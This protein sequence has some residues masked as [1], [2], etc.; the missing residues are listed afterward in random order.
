MT[1]LG[2]T[3]L[4]W[5][6]DHMDPEVKAKLPCKHLKDTMS[7]EQTL[8]R[9]LHYP[10]YKKGEEEPGAVRAAAHE[11][12]NLIT[13]L[14]AGSSKGLQVKCPSTQKWHEVPCLR[15]SII[16]NIGDML[17][18]MTEREYIATTHRVVKPED[19]IDGM[20]RMATPCFIHAKP[21]CFLSEKYPT[22]Q[23]FLDERLRELG[24]K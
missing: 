9:I 23:G 2:S 3:L 21:D 22:A 17:Q 24:V 11:D 19:E 15:G 4:D 12:I 1:D 13:V 14:P 8:L 6:D 18:E 20:D 7:K 5:I 10:A 16:I